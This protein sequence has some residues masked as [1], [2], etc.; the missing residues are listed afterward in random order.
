MQL[1]AW[2]KY[3]C[4]S[5]FVRTACVGLEN[6]NGSKAK[7]DKPVVH[8]PQRPVKLRRVE[9]LCISLEAWQLFRK[10]QEHLVCL[11]EQV[12]ESQHTL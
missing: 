7:A 2:T 1:L 5:I 12:R 11:I 3:A 10:I 4:T 8:L 6:F 9:N